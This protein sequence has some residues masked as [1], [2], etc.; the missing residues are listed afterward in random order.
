VDPLITNGIDP[1][2][3]RVQERRRDA[4]DSEPRRKRVPGAPGEEPET[5]EEREAET[6]QDVTKHAIDDLA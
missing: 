4:H 1:V 5:D 2:L 3:I 6:N